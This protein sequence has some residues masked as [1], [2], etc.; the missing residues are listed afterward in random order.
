M[1]PEHAMESTRLAGTEPAPVRHYLPELIRRVMHE[2]IRPG[3]VFDLTLPRDQG[4]IA[5]LVAAKVRSTERSTGMV[6]ARRPR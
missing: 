3:K 2:E 1:D 6:R 5:T 4:A